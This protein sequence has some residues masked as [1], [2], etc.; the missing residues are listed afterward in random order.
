MVQKKAK[1]CML[2]AYKVGKT[3]LVK[4]FISSQYDEKYHVTLGVKVDKKD[5]S[6][7]GKTVQLMLW[8]VAG[9]EDHF[10]VPAS[11]YRGSAGYLLVV[12][13]TRADTLDR[14][15]DLVGEIDKAVGRLPMV[16]LLNKAD[17]TDQWQLDE[18]ALAKLAPL[19]CPVMRTSAKTGENV[20]AAFRSLA[21]RVAS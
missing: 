4:R 5:V 21:A 8:D 16:V 9:A 17:L 2:G 15:L 3:S 12:D 19:N 20:D 7:G 6:V 18:A 1:I 11:Y 13:G 14:A 10:T